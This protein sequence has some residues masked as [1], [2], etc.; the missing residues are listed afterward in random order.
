MQ[1]TKTYYRIHH[2]WLITELILLI[3]VLAGCATSQS[4]VQ[5][6]ESA[7]SEI[8]LTFTGT[9][10]GI[11]QSST[12][13]PPL[14]PT[15]TA[16]TTS[17]PSITPSPTATF[18]PSPS[19]MPTAT[20][21][22]APTLTPLPTIPPQQHGQA[23][24]ELMSNNGGCTL[25]C[26]WGIEL[27]ITPIEYVAQ[28]YTSLG[29]FITTKDFENGRSRLTA[30]FVDPQIEDGI[31]VRH[32]FR[33]QDGIIIE[34]EIEIVWDPNYQI[35]PI[36][37]RLGQPPE[38]WM[39]TIPEPYEG[40]LPAR[41]RLYFPEQGVLIGY[42]TGAVKMDDAINVCFDEDGGV[43]MLL[44]DPDIWNP[45]GDKG[46]I[47]RTNESSELT[48]EGHQSIEGVSNWDVEEFYTILSASTH[49]ECLQTPSNLWS[50]P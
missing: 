24:A 21:T 19:A 5:E 37:Q 44:W 18:T 43:V 1:Q 7:M 41:F 39:W 25:P 36:L 49:S 40:V 4:G 22:P 9:V 8:S 31:Q 15:Q 17:A 30:L 32:M 16:T 28:L 34:A 26:W 47:E 20:F 42:G 10:I 33:A 27:G 13:T 46:F 29:A 45:T 3:V 35:E 11:P 48:L 23:Y 12:P 14:V 50:S 2:C 38:V 6:T